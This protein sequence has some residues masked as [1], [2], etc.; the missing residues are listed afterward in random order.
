M[1]FIPPYLLSTAYGEQYCHLLQ[2]LDLNRSNSNG[3]GGVIDGGGNTTTGVDGTI[4]L[5][6]PFSSSSSI[7]NN[8]PSSTYPSSS[9]LNSGFQT[10][11]ES[12]TRIVCIFTII[13]I[14]I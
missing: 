13:I 4:P 12:T 1:D 8:N 10:A 7:N 9:L 6:N 3:I 2:Y 11:I 14:F 5:L